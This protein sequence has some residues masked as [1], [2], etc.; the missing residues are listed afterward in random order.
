VRF[1]TPRLAL[2]KRKGE[3]EWKTAELGVPINQEDMA[4]TLL[5][6]AT[7]ALAGVEYIMGFPI[8]ESERRAYYHFWRY[9]GWVLGVETETEDDVDTGRASSTTITLDSRSRLRPLDPCGPGWIS[10]QPDSIAHSQAMMTS[11]VFHLM[12]HEEQL[13]LRTIYFEWVT[14]TNH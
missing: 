1:Y 7:N 11:F 8:P 2:L 13:K 3:R 9:I 12:G 4:A 10:K 14:E 6:F 5:A